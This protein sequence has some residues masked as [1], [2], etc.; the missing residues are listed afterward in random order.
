[1]K[2]SLFKGMNLDSLFGKTEMEMAVKVIINMAI[3][4][5][6]DFETC[7]VNLFDFD[8]DDERHGF[9]FL[10]YYQWLEEDG[11][12]NNFVVREELIE[13]LLERKMENING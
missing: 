13:R 1:M 12:G 4:N 10:L 6:D 2:P 9:C 3:K 11:G 5:G 8:R 7:S